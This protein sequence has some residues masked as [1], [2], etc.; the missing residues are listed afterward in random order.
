MDG[1]A[2]ETPLVGTDTEMK[3]LLGL[4]DVP[5]FARRGQD[6]E[7]A[8]ARL[9]QRCRRERSAMREMVVVRLRQWAAV[10]SG[11]ATASEVFATPIDPLWPSCDAPPPAWADREAPRR[12]L[13]IVGRDLVASVARF[14]ARWAR[15]LD[16]WNDEPINRLIDQYNRYYVLEKECSLGSA[17]LA[18]RHFVSKPRV[19]PASLLAA[20]PPLPLPELKP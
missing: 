12:R 16:E 7:Y 19:S 2:D 1:N 10:A 4:Y 8:L 5:A 11:P 15:F 20:Y 18:A 6:L 14:N 3:E 9:G 13:R 17:R